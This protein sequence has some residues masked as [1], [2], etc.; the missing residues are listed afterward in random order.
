MSHQDVSVMRVLS[1]KTTLTTG[2]AVQCA[3]RCAEKDKQER[4]GVEHCHNLNLGNSGQIIC[5]C[6]VGIS[7]MFCVVLTVAKKKNRL[8]YSLKFLRN[9]DHRP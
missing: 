5:S 3:G 4:I 6:T 8:H 2:Q 7:T 1:T 9:A